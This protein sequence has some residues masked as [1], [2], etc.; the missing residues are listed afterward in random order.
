MK[1]FHDTDGNP[2]VLFLI[3]ENDSIV[4]ESAQII[5]NVSGIGAF[6][7]TTDERMRRPLNGAGAFLKYDEENRTLKAIRASTFD[8]E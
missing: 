6:R 4:L 2:P 7:L 1:Y 5:S 8:P 3:G